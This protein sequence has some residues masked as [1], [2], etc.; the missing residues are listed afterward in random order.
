MGT[1]SD[2]FDVAEVTASHIA[3]SRG[4]KNDY[5]AEMFDVIKNT[6]AG[7]ERVRALLGKPI[8]VDS[9]YRCH[10]LNVAV[11]SKDTSDHLQGRAVDFICQEFG[12][13]LQICQFI[14]K[15]K[16][17]IRFKQLILEHTWVHISFDDP[18]VKAKLEVLSLLNEGKY[19]FGLTNLEGV[20][21]GVA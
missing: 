7:M 4:I 12:S 11:G 17:L 13:P 3:E 6:A 10:E 15:Y 8:H 16:E 20:P 2:H 5:P 1:L 21:Y 19:A 18:S 14:I 9:W